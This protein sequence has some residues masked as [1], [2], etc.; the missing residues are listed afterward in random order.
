M[1]SGFRKYRT[2]QDHLFRLE[3]FI[4]EGCI[5]KRTCIFNIFDMEKAYDTAWKHGVLRDLNKM[6]L[7]GKL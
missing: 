6:G 1:Q 2:T 3:S 5:K 4:Q 7:R